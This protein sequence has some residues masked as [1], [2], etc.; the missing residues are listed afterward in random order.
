M[1]L[2]HGGAADLWKGS[3]VKPN[4][5]HGRYLDDC[6]QCQAQKHGVSSLLGMDPETPANFIYATSDREYARYYASRAGRGWLYEVELDPASIEPSKEDPFPTWRASEARVVRVLEKRIT[7]T[8]QERKD[9]FIRWGGTEA[10]FDS[11]IAGL[12]KQSGR[13]HL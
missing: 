10:E 11:L 1:V 9:L 13:V 5:A 2:F 7:L 8:M 12:L 4:M 6:A 3:I